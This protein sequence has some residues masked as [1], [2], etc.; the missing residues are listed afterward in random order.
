MLK[1]VEQERNKLPNQDPS[2]IILTGISQG[3]MLVN[4]MFLTF[5]NQKVKKLT[6]A[7]VHPHLGGISCILGLQPLAQAN[8]ELKP[9]VGNPR[10]T[11]LYP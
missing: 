10:K 8:I 1:L 4:A 6:P 5:D 3:C 7:L 9:A 2:R 11:G